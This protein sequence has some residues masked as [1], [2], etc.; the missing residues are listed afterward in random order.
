MHVVGT[1]LLALL[2]QKI[3]N[4]LQHDRGLA[5]ARNAVHQ[6]HRH[7]FMA[8][9]Q[10]LFALDGGG[11]IPQLGR[12]VLRKRS[13]KQRVLNGYCGVKIGVKLVA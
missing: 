1:Q 9:Y 6:K 4:A 11:D 13:Q 12:A 8:H 7:I 3:G 10:V 5:A 2:I